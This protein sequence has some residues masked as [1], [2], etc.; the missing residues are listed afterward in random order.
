MTDDLFRLF[1]RML[2]DLRPR[3]THSEV[4]RRQPQAKEDHGNDHEDH[5]DIEK[6]APDD[7]LLHGWRAP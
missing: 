5:Q 6:S 4:A 2:R 3:L 1:R 7:V